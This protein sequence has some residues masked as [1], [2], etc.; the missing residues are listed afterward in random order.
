MNKDD[1]KELLDEALEPIKKTQKEHTEVLMR[2]TGALETLQSSSVTIENT[3][4]A[5][6][7]MYKINDSNVRKIEK[8]VETLEEEAGIQ[9]GPEFILADVR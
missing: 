2:H 7:D 9:P 4:N 5:Y 8:R 1:F 3:I 6:G